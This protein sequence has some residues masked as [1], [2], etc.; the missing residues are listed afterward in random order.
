MQRTI[1]LEIT[2]P[3]GYDDAAESTVTDTGPLPSA[4]RKP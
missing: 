2:A 3:E 4:R 1:L